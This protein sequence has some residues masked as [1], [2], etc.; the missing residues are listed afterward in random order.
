MNKRTLTL[1][2]EGDHFLVEDRNAP[3]SPP[4]GRGRT[5][6]EAMGRWLHNN[7]TEF[8]IAFE[9]DDSAQHAVTEWRKRE[10]GKR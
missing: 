3:G 5:Q 2:R 7:Q 9:V 8:G 10:V 1:S 6:M 4:V